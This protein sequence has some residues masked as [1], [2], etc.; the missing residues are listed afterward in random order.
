MKAEKG[1]AIS[2]KDFMKPTKSATR[3]TSRDQRR[4]GLGRFA[5]LNEEQ[6]LKNFDL[7]RRSEG[8]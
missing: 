8:R 7:I 2:A 3:S 4:G 1:F 6:D 5:T